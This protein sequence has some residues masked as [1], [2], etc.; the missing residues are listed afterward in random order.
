MS[1]GSCIVT[2]VNSSGNSRPRCQCVHPVRK[3]P[4]AQPE[5]CQKVIIRRDYR[6]TKWFEIPPYV[7]LAGDPHLSTVPTSG[8]ERSKFITTVKFLEKI[9][10]ESVCHFQGKSYRSSGRVLDIQLRTLGTVIVS[11]LG[12]FEHSGES[13]NTW[14]HAILQSDTKHL[15]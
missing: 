5:L 11:N 2:G 1:S 10:R 9:Q 6:W 15:T 8:V 12:N 7:P 4:K 3:L 14:N 13:C